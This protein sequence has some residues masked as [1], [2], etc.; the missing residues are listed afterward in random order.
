MSG[1]GRD[2]AGLAVLGEAEALAGGDAGALNG[3]RAGD[4]ER[5]G[6]GDAA[7]YADSRRFGAGYGEAALAL[8]GDAAVALDGGH[9]GGREHA[10]AG[11]ADD[12]IAAVELYE[13][14]RGRAGIQHGRVEREHAVF[15][16]HA[17]VC[18]VRELAVL[19]D[20]DAADLERGDVLR[21][22]SRG[23]LRGRGV[24][25]RG[26]GAVADLAGVLHVGVGQVR[27]G[28]AAAGRQRQ[29]QRER[30]QYAKVFLHSVYQS[31][32]LSRDCAPLSAPG[33]PP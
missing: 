9:T 21:H 13:D 24:Q 26:R 11:D 31:F 27:A 22:G 14:V 3:G 17:L 32:Q 1:R 23:R 16:L 29:H 18:K 12:E 25:V 4:L 7:L 19:D 20:G 6:D 28:V 2:K 30:K 5:A 10:L 8:D 33:S 15:I